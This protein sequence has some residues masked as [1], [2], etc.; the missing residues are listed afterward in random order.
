MLRIIIQLLFVITITIS[1]HAETRYVTD[2]ILIA[3]RPAQDDTS[4]PLEYLA[5]G[6]RI[7]VVEDLG[8]F[9]KIKSATGKVGFV[10]SKYFIPT[11]PAGGIGAT[12]NLQ[13][14]LNA[15]QKTNG[16]LT[17]EVQQL[18]AAATAGARTEQLP[19]SKKNPNETATL[20]KERDELKEEVVRLKKTSNYAPPSPSGTGGSQLQWFLAG[21]AIL[22]GWFAGRSYRPKRRF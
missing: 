7:E 4:P 6:M 12:A 10:R 16:E 14:Q 17:F 5:T 15:L 21:G 19:E 18:K 3:L 11:P 8:A 22:L 20:I 2:Q 9:L 1:A 13:E